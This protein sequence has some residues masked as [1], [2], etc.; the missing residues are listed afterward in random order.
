MLKSL[1]PTWMF[2]SARF[3][4]GLPPSTRKRGV[5]LVMLAKSE[6]SAWIT[7]SMLMSR[8]WA[9]TCPA[10]ALDLLACS[11]CACVRVESW[12]SKGSSSLHA[13]AFVQAPPPPATTHFAR[14]SAELLNVP[15]NTVWNSRLA[16]SWAVTASPS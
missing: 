4:A 15:M 6:T 10:R 2:C 9:P 5:R 8:W 1:P 14:V 11:K 16:R 3:S 13:P 12:Q 7:L